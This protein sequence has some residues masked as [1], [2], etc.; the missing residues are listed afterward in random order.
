MAAN[1]GH[2]DGRY[3]ALR[4]QFSRSDRLFLP[5][6]RIGFTVADESAARHDRTDGS[7]ANRVGTNRLLIPIVMDSLL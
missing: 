7:S 5:K 6:D 2:G 1:F 4:S 3:L